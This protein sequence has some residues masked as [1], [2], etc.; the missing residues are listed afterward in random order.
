MSIVRQK[1]TITKKWKTDLASFDD[2]RI[3]VAPLKEAT[4]PARNQPLGSKNP[5]RSRL[6][7]EI[8]KSYPPF[9]SLNQAACL[10]QVALSTMYE[11][12]SQGRLRLCKVNV[13]RHVRINR[14]RFV[15]LIESGKLAG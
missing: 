11:W 6:Y 15:R 4:M 3:P 1:Y 9:M 8:A 7:R 13:G 5:R 14:D 10:V 2:K 12:S